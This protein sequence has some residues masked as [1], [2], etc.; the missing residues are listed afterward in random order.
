MSEDNKTNAIEFCKFRDTYKR[1]ESQM[2]HIEQLRLGGMITWV[3]TS[4]ENI[5]EAFLKGEQHYNPLIKVME[6]EGRVRFFKNK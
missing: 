2:V 6:D 1:Y 5:Y 3:G 4:D